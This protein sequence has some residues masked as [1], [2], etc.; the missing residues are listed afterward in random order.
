MQAGSAVTIGTT[1]PSSRRSVYR[2]ANRDMIP[3]MRFRELKG[4]RLGRLLALLLASFLVPVGPA[5]AGSI[6][7]FFKA[8]GN[9]ISHPRPHPTP[10]KTVPAKSGTSHGGKTSPALEQSPSPSAEPP[11]SVSMPMTPTPAA[12]PTPLPE[13]TVRAATLPNQPT[14]EKRDIPYGIPVPNKQGF[15]TSPYAPNEGLVDVRGFASGTEVKDPYTGK[16]F[17]TP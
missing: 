16:I 9:S 1:P 4:S 5:R 8:V 2:S 14:R 11:S 6:G 3:H 12:R 7:D 13:P 17:L 10:R 15:V